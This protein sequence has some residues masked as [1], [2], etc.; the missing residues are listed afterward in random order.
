M[1]WA[2][3]YATT[4]E[5]RAYATRST[6]TVDDVELALA[7]TAA[8]RGVDWATHRQF[9]S[10]A[11]EERTYPARYERRRGRWLVEVDDLMTTVGLVVAGVAYSAE[12]HQLEPV[13]A[14]Q[15]GRPWEVIVLTSWPG[16]DPIV[17]AAW[18]WTAVPSP[19]KNATLLQGS[20]VFSRR[21]SP[22]GI[23]G[24]PELGSELRLL[25]KLDP[26]VA[27]M[28]APYVRWWGAR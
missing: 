28:V 19:V 9:G 6:E 26:D 15:R 4:A 17:E 23:A 21:T 7:V 5:L 25:A 18:G 10:V 2:P 16:D 14:P 20:R 13:N 8:S 11:A 12:L 3:D 22:H 27:V 24:S 1:A